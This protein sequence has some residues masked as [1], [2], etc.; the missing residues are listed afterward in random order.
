MKQRQKNSPLRDGKGE[1]NNKG[2]KFDTNTIHKTKFKLQVQFKPT[3]TKIINL[4]S[5]E[6]K[7]PAEDLVLQWVQQGLNRDYLNKRL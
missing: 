7:I 6:K 2:Y 5:V 4:V 1:H 3:F